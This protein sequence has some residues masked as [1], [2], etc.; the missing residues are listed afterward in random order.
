MNHQ[1]TTEVIDVLEKNG[2][3]LSKA[4]IGHCDHMFE[5]IDY[6]ESLLKRKVNLAFD[7]FGMD[8][9][10]SHELCYP[11]DYGRFSAIRILSN[12][13]FINQ[14]VVGHDV[15]FKVQLKEF[16]GFGYSHLLE[17]VVLVMKNNGFSEDE[18]NTLLVKNPAR[19]FGVEED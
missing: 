10:L 15:C 5:K 7:T 6:F 19:I 18:I 11:N 8:I 14:I 9:T 16:G 13:G 2:A 17:N 1:Y 3:D 12:M 4:I